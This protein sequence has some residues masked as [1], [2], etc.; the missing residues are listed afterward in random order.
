V[1]EGVLAALGATR[2]MTCSPTTRPYH[3]GPAEVNP[4]APQVG[5]WEVRLCSAPQSR[6]R[7]FYDVPLVHDGVRR[8][9]HRCEIQAP[10]RDGDPGDSSVSPAATAPARNSR[11]LACCV[12]R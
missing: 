2:L 4:C 3:A 10:R 7:P 6:L 5:F 8:D 1:F 12:Q 11:W 9:A